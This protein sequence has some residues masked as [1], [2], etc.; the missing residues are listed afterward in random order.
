MEY[1]CIAAAR[2]DSGPN[3]EEMVLNS[4][5]FI[6]IGSSFEGACSR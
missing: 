4:T 1:L 5:C 3:E 6:V 2:S